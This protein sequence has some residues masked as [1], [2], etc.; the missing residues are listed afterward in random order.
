MSLGFNGEV[1]MTEAQRVRERAG[2]DVVRKLPEVRWE[3]IRRFNQ[4]GGMIPGFQN[5]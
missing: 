1:T 2:R 5:T 4:N 3:P